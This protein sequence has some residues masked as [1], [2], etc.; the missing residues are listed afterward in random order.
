M[1]KK[2]IF[3]IE[4]DRDISELMQIVIKDNG[5]K[6]KTFLEAE[7][8][9][10]KIRKEKPSLL[11]MDLWIE[12]LDNTNLVKKLKKDP[13]TIDIPIILVSAKNSL[14]KIA[15]QTGADGFLSKPF[16][17]KD[18]LKIIEHYVPN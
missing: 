16:N 2:T 3:I 5:Y 15:K 4:D 13:K 11:V 10:N 12:G 1:S 7:N 18:L 8:L 14:E 6:V 9:E 17:I